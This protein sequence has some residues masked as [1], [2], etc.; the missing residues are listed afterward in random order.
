VTLDLVERWVSAWSLASCFARI[1]RRRAG[2]LPPELSLPALALVL[3]LPALAFLPPLLLLGMTAGTGETPLLGLAF[4]LAVSLGLALGV[5]T[6]VVSTGLVAGVLAAGLVLFSAVGVE[7]LLPQA[8]TVMANPIEMANALKLIVMVFLLVLLALLTSSSVNYR[9]T[10]TL[11]VP[12]LEWES[13]IWGW[14]QKYESKET[15]CCG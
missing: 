10:S 9:N 14:D 1:R 4:G 6:G 7:L 5:S 11:F 15:D 3:P 8:E 2:L 12:R 13:Q